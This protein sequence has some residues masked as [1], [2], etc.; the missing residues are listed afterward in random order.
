[1]R[2]AALLYGHIARYKRVFLF[3][4]LGDR[5]G[6]QVGVAFVDCLSQFDEVR[7]EDGYPQVDARFPGSRDSRHHRRLG[8]FF[9][10]WAN[11]GLFFSHLKFLL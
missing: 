1:M 9:K 4:G 6:V 2:L 8:K 11:P 3:E 5:G 10:T 7:L